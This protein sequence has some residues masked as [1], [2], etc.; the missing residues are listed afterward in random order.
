M[1][2]VKRSTIRKYT[3]LDS[4]VENPIFLQMITIMRYKWG[5]NISTTEIEQNGYLTCI[6]L[7]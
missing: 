3:G 7:E 4:V 6:I 5:T 1:P 2:I